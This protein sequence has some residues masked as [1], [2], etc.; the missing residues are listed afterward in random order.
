MPKEANTI[1]SVMII[2]SDNL[3]HFIEFTKQQAEQYQRAL[4]LPKQIVDGAV[5]NLNYTR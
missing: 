2:D 1:I 3:P 5:I 4:K